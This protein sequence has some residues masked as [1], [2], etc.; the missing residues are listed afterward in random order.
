MKGEG[1]PKYLVSAGKV[2]QTVISPGPSDRNIAWVCPS[3]RGIPK[4]WRYQSANF[5]GSR[6]FKKMP[7][8]TARCTDSMAECPGF[9]RV[10]WGVRRLLRATL[11]VWTM[12]TKS[13]WKLETDTQFVQ[14]LPPTGVWPNCSRLPGELARSAAFSGRIWPLL[15]PTLVFTAPPPPTIHAGRFRYLPGSRWLSPQGEELA[16]LPRSRP[17]IE[18]S[19]STDQLSL[20]SRITTGGLALVA[21]AGLVAVWLLLAR[22]SASA[23]L[24]DTSAAPPPTPQIVLPSVSKDEFYRRE[25]APLIDKA[26]ASNRASADK[27]LVR[28]HQE[29]DRFCTGIPGFVDDVSSWRTRFGFFRPLRRDKWREF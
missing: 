4:F 29:F 19:M 5:F 22:E 8:S 15:E 6:A 16:S 28:L 27:S 21:S 20:R 25:L 23:I 17:D 3:S 26:R 18:P 10:L 12:P 1:V 9:F 11:P 24:D 13:P 2:D 14:L 7:P